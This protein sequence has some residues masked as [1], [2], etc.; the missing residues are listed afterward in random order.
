M[1]FITLNNGIN[2]PMLGFGVYGLEEGA[3]CVNT[4][5]FAIETGY[6]SIDTASGYD[7]EKSVGQAI[8][9]SGVAR[10]DIFLTTKLGNG[11]QREGTVQAAFDESLAKLGLDYID[12]YIIHWPCPGHFEAAWLALEKIQASGKVR[13]VGVSNFQAHHIE[14]IKKTWAFAPALNQ[15]EL[16][17]LL[18]QKPLI[19]FCRENGI[20]PQAWSPLGG[21]RPLQERIFTS[22]AVSRL[23]EKYSKS[24][25][26]IVLRWNIECGVVT[27]PKSANEDRITQNFNIFDFALTPQEMTEIDALNENLRGGPDPD[28]FNF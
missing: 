7:N 18:T 25:A 17:P 1:K 24:P 23:A 4:V 2:M 5:R 15:I 26:Q 28:N 20:A 12:L 14:T 11:A 27:I 3:Q 13:A 16:H 8:R 10:D 22:P 19:N 9:E 21:N 6:R